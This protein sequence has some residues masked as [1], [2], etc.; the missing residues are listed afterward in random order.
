MMCTSRDTKRSTYF[1]VDQIVTCPPY[2]FSEIRIQ[3][4]LL[5]S[6]SSAVG[7]MAQC[8]SATTLKR[9]HFSALRNILCS[10]SKP[11]LYPFGTAHRPREYMLY[12]A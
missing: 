6:R 11:E 12:L 9:G 1:I 8:Y 10:Q 7:E 3:K 2:Y 4:M 5:F